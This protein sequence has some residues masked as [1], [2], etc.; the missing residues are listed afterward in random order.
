MVFKECA[1]EL[2]T[3]L[4]GLFNECLRAHNIPDDWKVGLVRPH[5]KGKA[6]KYDID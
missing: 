4:A 3:P 5:Y 1:N 2:K 6:S